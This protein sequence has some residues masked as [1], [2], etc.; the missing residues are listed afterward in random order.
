MSRLERPAARSIGNGEARGSGTPAIGTRRCAGPGDASLPRSCS[1]GGFRDP[2]GEASKVKGRWANFAC[3]M[4]PARAV[5]AAVHAS[6]VPS[7]AGALAGGVRLPYAW[8]ARQKAGWDRSP[9]FGRPSDRYP[10]L[11]LVI[12]DRGKHETAVLRRATYRADQLTHRGRAG[13][14]RSGATERTMV[15]KFFEAAKRKDA[16]TLANDWIK[17][18]PSIRITN[19]QAI[20]TGAGSATGRQPLLP[21]KWT[22]VLECEVGSN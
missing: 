12:A 8:R 16:E 17:A 19:R 9:G 5:L 2:G 15:R 7:A 11:R 1:W 18:N 22:I 3:C 14:D 4:R 13:G 21:K 10:R 20:G 6:R